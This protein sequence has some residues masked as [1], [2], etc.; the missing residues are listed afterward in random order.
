MDALVG[1]LP[2]VAPPTDETAI[3]AERE[4]TPAGQP[5]IPAEEL[6]ELRRALE[7]AMRS[8]QRAVDRIGELSRDSVGG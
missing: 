1:E 7:D 6:Q 4:P 2:A 3:G 5:A 8:L